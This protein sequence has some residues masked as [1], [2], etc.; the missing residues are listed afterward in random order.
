MFSFRAY[1]YIFI[2]AHTDLNRTRD[3]HPTNDVHYFFHAT[4]YSS[5]H[6]NYI[7]LCN[8]VIY[9][10]CRGKKN[11]YKCD[12]LQ[13]IALYYIVRQLY[14]Y[15]PFGRGCRTHVNSDR[16]EGATYTPFKYYQSFLSL[17]SHHRLE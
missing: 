7:I 16:E 2:Y 17:P 4:I 10:S 9:S 13:D 15:P 5:A 3:C 8:R 14:I 12:E 6:V 11:D 1:I